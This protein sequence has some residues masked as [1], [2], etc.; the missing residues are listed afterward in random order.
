MDEKAEVLNKFLAQFSPATSLFTPLKWM[1][2]KAG[3]GR[4][5][6]LSL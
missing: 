3:T 4:A 2:C 5:N 1:D 6:S